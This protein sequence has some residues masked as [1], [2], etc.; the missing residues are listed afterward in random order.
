MGHDIIAV[1]GHATMRDASTFSTVTACSGW[2]WLIGFSAPLFQFLA[3]IVARCSAFV[4]R[5]W[6]RRVAHMATKA[7]GRIESSSQAA[8]VF[9]AEDWTIGL[10]LW[11]TS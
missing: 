1:S 7:A 9:R 3:A 4:P 5:S 8:D 11:K 2:R 6:M 10:L